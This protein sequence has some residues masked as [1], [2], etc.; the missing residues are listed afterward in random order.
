MRLRVRGLD[1]VSLSRARSS[2]LRSSEH[3]LDKMLVRLNEELTRNDSLK[4]T[5]ETLR[6]DKL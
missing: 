1:S 5:I 4:A 2:Q 6:R 3:R